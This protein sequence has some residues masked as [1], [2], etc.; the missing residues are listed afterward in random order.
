MIKEC[1]ILYPTKYFAIAK[2]MCYMCSC[3]QATQL[4]KYRR[5]GI[6]CDNVLIANARFFFSAQE[7]ETQ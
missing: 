1:I 5:T 7:L 4:V 3:L 6:D 2:Q